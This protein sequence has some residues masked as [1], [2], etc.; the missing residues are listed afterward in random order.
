MTHK[1]STIK[2]AVTPRLR[3]EIATAETIEVDVPE[4]ME[5]A[6]TTARKLVRYCFEC[7]SVGEVPKTALAC[8]P[9]YSHSF[10]VPAELAEQARAGFKLMIQRYQESRWSDDE[11][12][13]P[14]PADYRELQAQHDELQTKLHNAEKRLCVTLAALQ[15]I[16]QHPKM[17]ADELGYGGCRQVARQAL[18]EVAL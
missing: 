4:G 9:D 18:K 14:T 8:C 10:Y 1:I 11:S 3:A 2:I 17:P 6:R 7:G 16:G 13:A 5:L 15:R 12:P